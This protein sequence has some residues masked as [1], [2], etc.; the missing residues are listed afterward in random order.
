MNQ[1]PRRVKR[2][3]HRWSVTL[4]Y[5]LV[6][7]GSDGES[8]DTGEIYFSVADAANFLGLSKNRIRDLTS[9]G[10]LPAVK[11][12]VRIV[13][14]AEIEKLY[15]PLTALKDY[16]NSPTRNRAPKRRVGRPR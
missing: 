7:G 13:R 12:K 1:L 14:L 5:P 4:G 2:D 8:E 15:I 9:S 3:L 10:R 11:R 6:S 16:Q